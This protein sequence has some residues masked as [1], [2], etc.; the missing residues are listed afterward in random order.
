MSHVGCLAHAAD[1]LPTPIAPGEIVSLFGSGLGPADP[2]QFRLDPNGRVPTTLAGV[3]VLFDG[4]AAPLLYVASGQ[5][6]AIVPAGIRGKARVTVRVENGGVSAAPFTVS[7]VDL[8]PAF[9]T[10]DGT[11]SGAAA[12]LNQDGTINTPA[13]P[14]HRGEV[15]ALFGTGALWAAGTIDGAINPLVINSL[16]LNF[17]VWGMTASRP[18]EVLFAGPAPGQFAGMFQ[19]NIRIPFDSWTGDHV[20]VNAGFRDTPAGYSQTIA[21]RE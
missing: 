18:V 9:F 7:V 13:N 19:L 3:R 1:L 17:E 11:G 6:N 4:I 10:L 2:A 16:P 14:A 21:I 12:A 5:I 8:A 20:P 15:V